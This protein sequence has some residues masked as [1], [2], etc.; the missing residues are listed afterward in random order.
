MNERT[1]D[2]EKTIRAL[3]CLCLEKLQNS[4]KDDNVMKALKF[5]MLRDPDATVRICALKTVEV[6][7]ETVKALFNATRDECNSIRKTGLMSYIFA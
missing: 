3:A 4:G 1:F 6:N 2:K 7:T 5:H